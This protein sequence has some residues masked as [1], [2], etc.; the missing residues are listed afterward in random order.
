M[1]AGAARFADRCPACGL[2]YRAF[3]VGD[4]PAA[5]LIFLVGGLVVGLAIWLELAAGPPWWVHLLLWPP[6]AAVA[7]LGGLRV[8]KGLLLHY[9]YRTAARE[10]PPRP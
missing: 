7:T 10:G 6:L 5:F 8:A 1:F 4:G 9:E 2:D 3:D